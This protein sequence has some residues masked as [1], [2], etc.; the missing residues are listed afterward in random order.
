MAPSKAEDDDSDSPLVYAGWALPFSESVPHRSYNPG[1]VQIKASNPAGQVFPSE[2]ATK[3]RLTPED[4]RILVAE[5]DRA[6][7]QIAIA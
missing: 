2:L 7:H 3:P 4:Y 1:P 6:R 5:I